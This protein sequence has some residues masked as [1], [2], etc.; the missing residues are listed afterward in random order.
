VKLH[1]IGNK[2]GSPEEQI[3]SHGRFLGSIAPV[4][5][6]NSAAPWPFLS[7]LAC[8]SLFAALAYP[9]WWVA[10]GRMPLVLRSEAWENLTPACGF[11]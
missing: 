6:I 5:L 11:R 2:D 1:R 10:M 4:F 8:W 7:F 3:D 9:P